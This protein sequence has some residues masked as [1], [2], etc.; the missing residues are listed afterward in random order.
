MPFTY[1]PGGQAV[2]RRRR[3]A[4][5]L[6]MLARFLCGRL[7]RFLSNRKGNLTVISAVMMTSLVGVAGLVADFGNGLF[8]R[9]QDQRVA[10]IAAV[11]GATVYDETGSATSMNTAVTNVAALN[12]ISSG[13]VSATV[14]SSP[15]GDGNTAV[16]V[17]VSSSVPLTLSR[18]LQPT[19]ASTI[20]VSA[21]S[22]AEMKPGGQGCIVALNT[23]GTGISTSGGTA[24][25]ASNC[26]VAS[27]QTITCLNGTTITASYAY[28]YSAPVPISTCSGLQKSGGG[29]PTE[30]QAYTSDPIAGTSEV[31]GQTGR[32]TTVEAIASPT[33]SPS[34]G[35]MGTPT[36]LPFG[37]SGS[38]VI[39]SALSTQGC[40]GSYAA[41]VW[42]VTCPAGQTVTFGMISVSGSATVN[43]NVNG[44]SSNTY[45]FVQVATG[46]GTLNFGPGT[47]NIQQGILTTNGSAVT[48]FG[49]GTFNVGTPNASTTCN[50]STKYSLC[51]SATTMTFAGPSTFALS[52]GIY[53]K[54]NSTVTL[55]S[56]GTTNSFNIGKAADGNSIYMGGGAIVTFGDATGTGDIF[57]MAGNMNDPNGGSC[58]KFGAAANHDINGSFLTAGGNILGSGVYTVANYMS[59]GGSNGGNVT[60]WGTSTG[61][62]ASGV[63][64]VV[65]GNMLDASGRAFYVGAGYSNVT[66]T[67]PTSGTTQGLAVIGPTSS[68]N[69]GSAAFNEGSSNTSISGVFYFPYGSITQSG[70]SHIG[71]G[72]GQCLELYGAQVSL[73]GG[74]ALASSCNIPGVGFSDKGVISLVQ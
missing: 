58:L 50:S 54:G 61:M 8:N 12:G 23:G 67:A 16:Q 62:S 44:S 2:I 32:L 57:Q 30:T 56:S 68:S 4:G 28:V 21:S 39:T 65:G 24:I 14:V 69:T 9:L 35:A 10:D 17:R 36:S 37:S 72:S 48:T 45:N 26:A 60:C 18:V 63:T 11:A 25:T 66:L 27:N 52:G 19:L 33:Y 22:F 38:G 46:A 15:T 53:A 74:A 70:S 55:G 71:D 47:Y 41:S 3:T 51:N 73:T 5:A 40:S 6:L 7:G 20:P 64:M 49:A 59:L 1:T 13:N 31:L 42:T 43:F 29:T 34:V